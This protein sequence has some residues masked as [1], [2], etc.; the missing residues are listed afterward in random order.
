MIYDKPCAPVS[1]GQVKQT[2]LPS[3]WE[4]F[5]M[6][7]DGDESAVTLLTWVLFTYIAHLLSIIAPLTVLYFYYSFQE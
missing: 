6:C 1:I 7:S 2:P 5:Q 3:A 4:E